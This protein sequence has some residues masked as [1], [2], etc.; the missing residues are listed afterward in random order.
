[1]YDASMTSRLLILLLIVT[2]VLT[3][4][5]QGAVTLMFKQLF[6]CKLM[7]PFLPAASWINNTHAQKVIKDDV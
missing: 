4:F 1:M 2:G 7:N 3:V 6:H 5:N